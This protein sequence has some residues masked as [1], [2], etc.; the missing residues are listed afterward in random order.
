M[1]GRLQSLMIANGGLVLLL[2]M[3]AGLPF[4]FHLIGRIELWPIPFTIDVQIHGTERGWRAAHIGNIMNGTM[5]LA[6]AAVLHHLTL[7][8]ALRRALAWCL[9]VTVW[10]NAVFY[11]VAACLTDGRALTFGPNR[12]GGGDWW[13]SVGFLTAM[14]AVVTVIFALVQLVRGAFASAR[15][16]AS[17]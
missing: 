15:A 13:N 8:P 5:L 2:G 12:F 6:V 11:V 4:A 17:D 1:T 10:G 16:A 9:I 3:L 14:A 7:P